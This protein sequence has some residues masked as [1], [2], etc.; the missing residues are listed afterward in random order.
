MHKQHVRKAK[1]HTQQ[2]I[3]N[4][5][6][7]FN[8]LKT[9]QLLIAHYADMMVFVHNSRW[10]YHRAL[11]AFPRCNVFEC[12]VLFFLCNP[13]QGTFLN[14]AWMECFFFSSRKWM[15]HTAATFCIVAFGAVFV[16]KW[17]NNSGDANHKDHSTFRWRVIT[18]SR[19]L[20]MFLH[21]STHNS[22]NNKQI[23]FCVCPM[24]SAGTFFLLT[25]LFNVLCFGC[26]S[27]FCYAAVPCVVHSHSLIGLTLVMAWQ[28]HSIAIGM[29]IWRV[30]FIMMVE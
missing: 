30:Y 17:T 9:F 13:I 14:T 12:V 24:L 20:Y 26:V 18:D 19:L 21:R 1:H 28:S 6:K 10:I 16:W 23:Q 7:R 8:K 3:F 25:S 22:N 2:H 29:V 27:V 11:M 5:I 4:C 15:K